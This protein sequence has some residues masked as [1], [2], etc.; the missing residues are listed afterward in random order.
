MK[1]ISRH[2]HKAEWPINLFM[3]MNHSATVQNPVPLHKA[4]RELNE[5]KIEKNIFLFSLDSDT[6]IFQTSVLF[7]RLSE[8]KLNEDYYFSSST[9]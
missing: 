6:I 4:E 9:N 3:F 7:A 5:R 8:R 2:F 1:T